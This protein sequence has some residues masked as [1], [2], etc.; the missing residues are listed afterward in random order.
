MKGLGSYQQEH[1]SLRIHTSVTEQILGVT[2]SP[3]FHKQLEAEQN[4]LAGADITISAEYIEESIN[5]QDDLL[6]VLR[7]LCLYSLTNEGI[8]PK[9][10]EFF[11]REIVQTYGYEYL[12]ALNNLEK[13]GLFNK[14]SVRTPPFAT[15]RKA[16]NLVVQDINE[17][18]PTDISY[19]YSGYAP[20]SVRLVQWATRGGS[21]WRELAKTGLPLFEDVQHVPG[22]DAPRP[23]GRNQVILLCFIGGITFTEISAIRFL[24]Q[25]MPGYDF[26]IC[27]T[28]VINGSSLLYDTV[29]ASIEELKDRVPQ[30]TPTPTPTAAKR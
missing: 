27:T 10:H 8:K 12:A 17:Q 29:L 4:L 1:Q 28:K 16:L 20:L 11:K 5:K 25:I 2:K 22:A 26:V 7:L 19:V 6:K 18:N 13:L 3:D 30:P 21:G 9:T 24:N 14:Q 15:L 23:P